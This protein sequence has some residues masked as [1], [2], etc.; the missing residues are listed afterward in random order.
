M[1]NIL[2]H[3]YNPLALEALHGDIFVDLNYDYAN[4]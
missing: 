2:K 4:S 1:E 3:V